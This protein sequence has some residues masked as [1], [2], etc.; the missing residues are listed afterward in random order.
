MNPLREE[1]TS[2][3][4]L[5]KPRTLVGGFHS[6]ISIC[7]AGYDPRDCKSDGP[8]IDSLSLWVWGLLSREDKKELPTPNHV[9]KILKREPFKVV[10]VKILQSVRE[11][12]PD[13]HRFRNFPLPVLQNLNGDN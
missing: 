9:R 5:D 13:D 8:S 4:V 1:L 10:A 7:E 3:I 11:I 2:T 12:F 6:L